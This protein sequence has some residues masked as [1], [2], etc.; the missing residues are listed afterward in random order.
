MTAAVN[1]LYKREG[2][3][4]E[5]SSKWSV[6]LSTLYKRLKA[7][8]KFLNNSEHPKNRGKKI[9]C[10]KESNMESAIIDYIQGEGSL[11]KIATKWSVPKT[12]LEKRVKGKV[13]GYKHCSG[14]KPILS[15]IAEEELTQNIQK[16]SSRGFPLTNKE[17]KQIAFQYAERNG[18]EGFSKIR[19][20]AGD[21][22]LRNFLKRHSEKKSI[23]EIVDTYN[24]KL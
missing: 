23:F 13:S 7:V 18:I 12:T 6:P 17:I 14:R 5:I 11:R 1:A 10:W 8:K 15:R 3:I 2:S 19:T 9:N 20:T 24:R 4:R 22:W 16:L 21:R